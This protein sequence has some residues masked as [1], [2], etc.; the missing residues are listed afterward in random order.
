M[1]QNLE[2][3]LNQLRF[4]S[5]AL[6]DEEPEP[7][8]KQIASTAHSKFDA[9]Y[10]QVLALLADRYY[11]NTGQGKVGENQIGRMVFEFT[12]KGGA[13]VHAL[14]LIIAFPLP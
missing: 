9:L 7:S 6:A 8:L 12:N 10:G 11:V 2:G 3:L 5:E 4:L 1:L 14:D 13:I